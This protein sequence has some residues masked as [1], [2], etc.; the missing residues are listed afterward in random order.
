VLG[1]TRRRATPELCERQG[2]L[3]SSAGDH[4]LVGEQARQL[5]RLSLMPIWSNYVALL[6]PASDS[7]WAT[8]RQRGE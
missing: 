1:L 8:T 2:A 3:I 6:P 5:D 7:E 4:E